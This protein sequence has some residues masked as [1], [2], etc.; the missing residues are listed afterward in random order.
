MKKSGI[1]RREFMR[2]VATTSL[3]AAILP[4]WAGE[5]ALMSWQN[6][7]TKKSLPPLFDCNKYLGM[8]FPNR[9]DFPKAVDLLAHMERL[10]IDR[11]VAWHTT[12][13]NDN[14]MDGNE[15]LL[16]EINSGNAGDRILP[17]FIIA[18]SVTED[19]R[20]FESG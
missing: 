5:Q 19:K 7:E 13:R 6:Q 20:F 1:S 14:P 3:S 8:G 12:A 9:P 4:S 17:S 11:S 16:R 18:P 15:L 2:G 10:G